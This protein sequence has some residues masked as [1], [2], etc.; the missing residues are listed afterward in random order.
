MTTLGKTT[1]RERLIAGLVLLVLAV[2]VMNCGMSADPAPYGWHQEASD[3][4]HT[5]YAPYDLPGPW[6]F[7]WQWNGSCNSPLGSDCRPGDPQ[8]GW[9][10]EVPARSHPVAGDGH[11]YLPAGDHGVYAI[12]EA[13]GKTAWHNGSITSHVTAAFD[14]ETRSLFVAGMDAKLYK[15]SPSGGSVLGTF[16]ADAA[17]DLAPIIV[18]GRVY[19]VS[20][21]GTLY[22]VD[23]YAMSQ[24]W[25]YV[26]GSR[27]QTPAA[28]SARRDMLVFATEDLHVHAVSNADGHQMWRT[29]PTPN[30]PGEPCYDGGDG[31]RYRKYNYEHG[32]PVIAEEHGIVF[33]RQHQPNQDI[34]SAT[35][36]PNTNAGVRERLQN[37]PGLQTL[38][39]LRL[40]DG[41]PAFTPAVGPGGIDTP[42]L[43][44]GSTLGP[45]PVVRE[46]DGSEV[47]YM[48]WRN[49]QKCEAGDCSDS[50]WDAVMGEMVLDDSTV[51]GYRA[52][53]LRFINFKSANDFLISDEMGKLTMSG[54]TIFH[55]HW[56][57]LYSY[58]M[59]DRS[60]SRGDSYLNP[61][62]ADER[63][64][65]ANRGS[66][67]PDWV[68]YNP[69]ADHRA[70]DAIFQAFRDG[71][72][73]RDAFWVF[74]NAFDPPYYGCSTPNCGA[75]YGDGYKGRYAIVH[76]GTIY[77]QTNGGSI[78]AVSTGSSG[79][80]YVPPDDDPPGSNPPP[81]TPPGD[82][83]PG[84][85]RLHLP[86]LRG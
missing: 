49:G 85:Y 53:D 29:K 70:S 31:R 6:E 78:F 73:F 67:E 35:Y 82:P 18:G 16:Q 5:G 45:L 86:A 9:S 41:R 15:L 64:A 8:Q 62:P 34:L 54:D 26:A 37:N 19:V 21:R 51:P 38:F 2:L 14:P 22:A 46:V 33:I 59:T 80:V 57:A 52:G 32:W 84:A 66:S 83:S 36:W 10:F 76:D 4:Q 69:T 58:R 23:K 72:T 11:L 39:A 17:L 56:L 55:S 63:P 74:F 68:T 28:Y 7:R 75:G 12:R 13:D 48:I 47:A 65:I 42:E 30:E 61:I 43:Y 20:D 77:Y 81:E 60:A 24:V 25:S 27:G 71:R 40:E 79:S 1:A 44:D 3:A 50:R